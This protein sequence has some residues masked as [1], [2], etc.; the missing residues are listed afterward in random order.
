MLSAHTCRYPTPTESPQ[1][2]K[3]YAQVLPNSGSHHSCDSSVFTTVEAMR[4]MWQIWPGQQLPFTLEEERAFLRDLEAAVARPSRPSRDD[5]TVLLSI[6]RNG[7]SLDQACAFAPGLSLPALLGAYRRLEKSR[8]SSVDAWVRIAKKPT[9][10]TW[11][12]DCKQAYKIMPVV[13]DRIRYSDPC[14]DAKTLAREVRAVSERIDDVAAT[15][16]E[17]ESLVRSFPPTHPRTL[18]LAPVLFSPHS[19]CLY[20]DPFYI[21]NRISS[22]SPTRVADLLGEART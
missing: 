16:I 12:A 20:A 15:A 10:A 8:S 18:E 11:A 7:C 5:V 17:L 14:K 21:P 6:L 13:I 19:N 2:P 9:P 22:L 1:H 3:S 4:R